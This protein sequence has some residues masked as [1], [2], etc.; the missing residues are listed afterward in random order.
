MAEPDAKLAR[1]DDS[2]ASEISAVNLAPGLGINMG[3]R[4]EVCGCGFPVVSVFACSLTRARAQV[5]WD[6]ER[7]SEE[8][9]DETCE[10]VWW[11]CTV[12]N[13]SDGAVD[14]VLDDTDTE[15]LVVLHEVQHK[16]RPRGLGLPVN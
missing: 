7:G 11:P 16:Y 8:T 14:L 12:L 10:V 6:V 3:D 9:G 1:L 2:T 4:I 13:L 5:L 15:R